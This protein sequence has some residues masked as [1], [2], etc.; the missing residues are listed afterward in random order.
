MVCESPASY[1][2]PKPIV[3][4][5][6]CRVEIIHKMVSV[7]DADGKLLKQESIAD[8]TRENI[9]GEY[10]SLDNFI[11]KWSAEQKKDKIRELLLERGIDLEALKSD[12]GMLDVDDYDFLCHVAFDKKPLTRRER[13]NNVRKRDFF[14]RYNGI[15]REVLETLLDKY[16]N[17]GI[18]EI[19]KTEILKLDPFMKLGKPA[20]I[21]SYFGGKE[22]YLKAVQE[23]ED[24]IYEEE[25]V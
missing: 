6:G 11:R 23:L 13:A 22:G 15:A 5:N 20:K 9:R 14:S 10:A 8:Y 7:Y 3:D 24:A 2:Q 17:T 19:E 21:A 18:Y 1:G 25:A 4:A 12:Q 16:M